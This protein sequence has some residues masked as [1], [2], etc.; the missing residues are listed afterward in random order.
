MITPINRVFASLLLP[1]IA[2]T[3]V[4]LSSGCATQAP[5][6]ETEEAKEAPQTVWPAPPEQPR[7][8]YIGSL[9][10][11][12]DVAGK[13]K[14]SMRDILMGEEEKGEIT[15]LRKPFGV[16]SDS[17]GRVFVADT[18]FA[19]LIVFDLAKKDVSFWG[20]TGL[21]AL[22]KP[23]G[24]TSD[25]SGRVYVSDVI[26]KRVVVFDTNGKYL[27]AFG[28]KEVLKTPAGLVF[29]DTTQQLYVVDTKRHQI[30][31]FNQRGE[32]DFI[33]GDRGSE[34][35]DFNFPT[36]IATDA[37]GRLYVSDTM[38]FRIQLLEADGTFV[39]TFG[40]VGD[41]LGNVNRLK[42]IGVDTEGH[43]YAVDA[44]YNNFQIF[45]QEGELLLFV[46]KAGI[47]PGEFSMPAG[48]HVDRNNKIFI[49]DQLNRRIE[50]FEY[51][52]EPSVEPKPDGNSGKH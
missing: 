39:R 10:S 41:R 16:H 23:V 35:G 11:L 50:M 49:A 13:K 3:L 44:S 20:V 12:E 37:S 48:A 32:I 6:K 17:K 8:R 19:G 26:D 40:E 1:V 15:A 28:G 31:V 30:L 14:K 25:A 21:G 18:G 7:I 52:G 24:V 2:V 22:T 34:H 4:A 27:N 36:N 33:I 38:N 9:Q 46:G 45:N 51:L 5:V 42:G 43:I 47:G 29:N